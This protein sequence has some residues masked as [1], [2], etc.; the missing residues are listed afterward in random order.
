[1]IRK[2][3]LI[4]AALVAA[5]VTAVLQAPVPYLY[6]WFAP[7]AMP[8]AVT[9]M[10]GTIRHGT[11][12]AIAHDNRVVARDLQWQWR[13]H[14]LLGLGLGWQLRFAGPVTGE[15]IT[16]VSAGGRLSVS[17]LRAIGELDAIM[18][19]AGFAG[20]PLSGRAAARIE[21]LALNRQGIPTQL[22]GHAELLQLSWDVGR[23]PLVIGD[24]RADLETDDQGHLVARISSPEDSPVEAT[25]EARLQPD[26]VYQADIRVRARSGASEQVRSILGIIGQ[27]D[28]QGYY[29]LRQRGRL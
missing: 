22:S 23:T 9:G 5:L 13:P 8:V 18:A 1:M 19:A 17:G 20:L 3:W 7:Q 27:P 16:D 4:L 29:R 12:R 25:G 2:R 28:R 6:G 10:D 14:R 24:F 15:A 26:G 21:A 11:I